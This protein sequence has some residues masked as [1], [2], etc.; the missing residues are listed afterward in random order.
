M[1]KLEQL[2]AMTQVVADTGDV[3]AIAKYQP[4]DATT[5]PSLILKAIELPAY[6]PFFQAAKAT[7]AKLPRALPEA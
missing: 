4:V 3:E 5:N 6:Q 2:K 1:N 7:I